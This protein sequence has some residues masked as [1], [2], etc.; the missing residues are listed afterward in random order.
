M[1]EVLIGYR[2]GWVLYS[3]F[4]AIALA[5]IIFF[6]RNADKINFLLFWTLFIYVSSCWWCWTYGSTSFGQRA[7]VDF[8]GIIALQA[9]VF[10]NYFYER[11][12]KVLPVA[13][14]ISTIPLCLLQTHQY[15]HG[16]IP[17]EYAS[18]E[19]Y[20]GNFFVTYPISFY[21]IPK[22]A[23]TDKQEFL[24][25]FDDSRYSVVSNEVT[26]SGKDA[27][28]INPVHSFSEHWNLKLPAFMVPGEHSIVRITSM[29][30]TFDEKGRELLFVDFSRDGKVIS[31]N[32]FYATFY[33][34]NKKWTKYQIGQPI[35]DEVLPGDSVSVYFQKTDGKENVYIDDVKVEFIHMDDSYEFKM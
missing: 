22:N 31:H 20:F 33:L 15:K 23:I 2:Q 14:A 7:F 12:V 18:A 8:Y 27:T 13:V 24:F 19:T 10:F 16:I 34:R 26:Y 30:N 32:Q 35:P 28:F 1:L 29:M 11:K 4:M 6:K 21:P 25:S 3:P 9:A 17:G 5:G